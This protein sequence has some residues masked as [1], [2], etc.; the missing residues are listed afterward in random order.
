[1]IEADWTRIR[2]AATVPPGE[3]RRLVV[4]DRVFVLVNQA[5]EYFV[6]DARC[7][8]KPAASLAEGILFDNTVMCP[9]HG[10]RYDIRTGRN[11]HPGSARSVGCVPV[12]VDGD[13]LLL[14]LP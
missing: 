10:F 14:A 3:V 7:T 13:D 8:H 5:G 11:V 6:L 2:G 12:R 9:W 1:M 4:G